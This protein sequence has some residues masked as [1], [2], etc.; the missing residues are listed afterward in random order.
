MHLSDDV[1]ANRHVTPPNISVICCLRVVG[2]RARDARPVPWR[3]CISAEWRRGWR[4]GACM[5]AGK[6]V[7]RSI[8]RS[9]CTD[10]LAPSLTPALRWSLRPFTLNRLPPP[11]LPALG[12]YSLP[13]QRRRGCKLCCRRLH[14]MCLSMHDEN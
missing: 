10:T 2:R 7:S 1:R 13:S 6:H 4:R 3:V 12:V 11:L 8:K 14:G 9:L 5:P